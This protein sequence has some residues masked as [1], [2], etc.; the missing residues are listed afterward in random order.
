M[1]YVD[2]FNATAIEIEC[3]F[4]I[5]VIQEILVQFIE[6]VVI[7]LYFQRSRISSTGVIMYFENPSL[8][9]LWHSGRVV[10]A[11]DLKSIGFIPRRFEP[12]LRRFSFSFCFN[13]GPQRPFSCRDIATF[14][15][16]KKI[17]APKFCGSNFFMPLVSHTV[18]PSY[19]IFVTLGITL[20]L[21]RGNL[22][23]GRSDIESL[24]LNS[25]R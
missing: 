14:S 9:R 12:C 15:S 10:K 20:T 4:S 6:Q 16:T 18:C 23:M 19:V 1:N 13:S 5:K 11:M 7:C 21:E 8:C 2:F 25:T 22:K 17:F 3:Q 24:D